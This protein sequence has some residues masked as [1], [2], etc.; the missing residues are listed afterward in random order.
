[1]LEFKLATKFAPRSGKIRRA[2]KAGFEAAEIRLKKKRLENVEKVIEAISGYDFRFAPHFPNKGRLEKSHLEAFVHLY[3]ELNSEVAVIH[4]P[5]LKAYGA[6]L[7]SIASGSLVLAVE[8]GR[9]QGHRL[10]KWAAENEF[11]TLDIEHLWKYALADSSFRH[12]QDFLDHFIDKFGSKIRHIHMPGY[13][14][15][16][17]EHRPAYLNPELSRSVWRKLS[18]MNFKGLAVSE[19]DVNYQTT[20]HLKKD[21]ALFLQWIETRD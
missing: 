18:R 16:S 5:M 17:E 21:A 1:M 4:P 14:P 3:Q 12:F 9:E 2:S 7:Q 19:L 10:E 13:H 6:S 20:T 15:G 8:N 11:L